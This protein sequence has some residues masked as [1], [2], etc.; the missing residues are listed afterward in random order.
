M[1]LSVAVLLGATLVG[2]SIVGAGVSI[3]GELR[4]SGFLSSTLG[5]LTL[6]RHTLF[7]QARVAAEPKSSADPYPAASKDDPEIAR[8]RAQL[9]QIEAE[10]ARK[11]A[12][13]KNQPNPFEAQLSAAGCRPSLFGML[14]PKI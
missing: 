12:E 5:A 1:K 11:R 8:L 13:T 10:Q 4:C 9:A 14:G 6:E 3:G 7:E 2:A